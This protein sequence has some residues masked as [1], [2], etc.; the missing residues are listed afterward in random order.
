MHR[1]RKNNPYKN[2]YSIRNFILISVF[3]SIIL[4]PE[5]VTFLAHVMFGALG[6]LRNPFYQS[7][8][9]IMIINISDTS[10]YVM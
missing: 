8:H 7:F 1:F 2:P 5:I 4:Q 3:R 9:L 6:L 10:K